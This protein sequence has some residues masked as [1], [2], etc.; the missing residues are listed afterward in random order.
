[1]FKNIV[2]QLGVINTQGA[3]I[4]AAVQVDQAALDT[5]ATNLEAAKT[6]LASEIASLQVQLPAADL[7]GLNK[8]LTDLQGLEP[9]APTPTP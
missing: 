9:P 7:T 1:M 8:A 4:M 6:A 5:L 3:A 2:A